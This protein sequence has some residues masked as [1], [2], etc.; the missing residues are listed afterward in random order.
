MFGIILK[1]KTM[2]RSICPF[3]VP[4]CIN[5]YFMSYEKRNSFHQY[6]R[7]NF[8]YFSFRSNT[9]TLDYITQQNNLTLEQY[10]STVESF[11]KTFYI[12]VLNYL[13]YELNIQDE[14]EITFAIFFSD[15]TAMLFKS[16]TRLK[17]RDLFYNQ[18]LF[19]TLVRP[20][21]LRGYCYD[22]NVQVFDFLKKNKEMGKK[23][24]LKCECVTQYF[25]YINELQFEDCEKTFTHLFRLNYYYLKQLYRESVRLG[26]KKEQIFR[27]FLQKLY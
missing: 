3:I 12:M 1:L 10:I 20:K 21:H 16:E 18:N 23:M 22:F 15:T 14:K 27:F 26:L 2:S 19:W 13:K 6:F 5:D 11:F 9:N 8:D 25:F 4:K 7:N 17:F 24:I